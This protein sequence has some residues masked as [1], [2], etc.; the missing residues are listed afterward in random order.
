[1]GPLARTVRRSGWNEK[2]RDRIKIEGEIQM[3]SCRRAPQSHGGMD[4]LGRGDRC[5]QREEE[6]HTEGG[7]DADRGRRRY[8]QRTRARQQLNT[9]KQRRQPAMHCDSHHPT[10]Q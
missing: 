9:G 10:Y 6:I 1:M 7:G 3:K 5:R 4:G 8:K 2:D